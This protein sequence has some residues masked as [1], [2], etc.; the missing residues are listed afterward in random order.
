MPGR[1]T[2]EL[3]PAM[4]EDGS[5]AISAHTGSDAKMSKDN[6]PPEN[7]SAWGMGYI[8]FLVYISEALYRSVRTQSQVV[9]LFY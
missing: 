3:V 6:H 9:G 7:H 8:W 5:K 2:V 4:H 1:T